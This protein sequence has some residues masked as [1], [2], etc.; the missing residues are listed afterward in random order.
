MIYIS[1]LNLHKLP[2]YIMNE[3]LATPVKTYNYN[4]ID[5]EEGLTLDRFY[6]LPITIP[7][8]LV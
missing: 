6:V 2:I 8:T 4:H 7:T 1:N 5:K 3:P